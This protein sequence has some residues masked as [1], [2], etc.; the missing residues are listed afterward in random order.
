MAVWCDSG[1]SGGQMS[2]YMDLERSTIHCLIIS[3][4]TNKW[5]PSNIPSFSTFF[6]SLF[7]SFYF[8]WFTKT[9]EFI[10]KEL[11]M[12]SQ[13]FLIHSL[14][15]SFYTKTNHSKYP[16]LQRV[17]L[18]SG[19]AKTFSLCNCFCFHHQKHFDIYV[20]LKKFIANFM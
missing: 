2:N 4:H 13:R 1:I 8:S 3:W 19:W 14:N 12:F 16:N 9:R 11:K 17:P 5:W 15:K 20:L 7:R 18:P 10:K 6:Y